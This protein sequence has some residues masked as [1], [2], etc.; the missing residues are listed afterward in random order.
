MT[1]QPALM[2]IFEAIFGEPAMPLDY[3]WPRIAGP[4]AGERP[5]SD[6]VYMRRGTPRLF[7][8][9]MPLMDIPMTSGPLMVLENSHLDNPHTRR[10]LEMDRRQAGLLRCRAATTPGIGSRRALQ[11]P[12]RPRPQRVWNALAQH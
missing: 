7:S 4:G 5:H 2:A 3:S 6:W 12:S 1:H 9:W 11:R 8:A 10:Y